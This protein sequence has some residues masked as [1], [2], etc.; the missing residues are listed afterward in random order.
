[1]DGHFY[2][3]PGEFTQARPFLDNTI[4][5]VEKTDKIDN[6]LGKGLKRRGY[7]VE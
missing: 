7:D 5:E 4:E 2:D 3:F 1:M 6:V